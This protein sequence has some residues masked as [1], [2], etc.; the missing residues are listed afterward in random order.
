M[1]IELKQEIEQIIKELGYVSLESVIVSKEVLDKLKA[2]IEPKPWEP[3][4]FGELY[5]LF[6][7]GHIEKRDVHS[8]QQ[9]EYRLQGADH[10]T[11]KLAET[12]GGINKRNQ[13]ILQAKTERG[14][15]DGGYEIAVGD[16]G[17]WNTHY[18]K[19]SCR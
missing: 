15:G 5:R 6:G 2:L 13:L 1:E 3:E 4:K 16:D 18:L 17:K 12:A 11:H 14:F 10:P 19:M 7:D 8:I 9:D